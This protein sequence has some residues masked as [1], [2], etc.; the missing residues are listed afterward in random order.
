MKCNYL[1]NCKEFTGRQNDMKFRL[2]GKTIRIVVQPTVFTVTLHI[3]GWAGFT[4]DPKGSGHRVPST[5]GSG[6]LV[7]KSEETTAYV[8]GTDPDS[9]LLS[10]GPKVLQCIVV[11]LQRNVSELRK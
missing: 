10:T 4:H 9:I 6:K 1:V 8:P 7:G 3:L 5:R 2:K 11:L